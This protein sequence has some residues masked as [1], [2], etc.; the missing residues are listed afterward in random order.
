VTWSNVGS[1]A[2]QTASAYSVINRNTDYSS[3]NPMAG[4]PYQFSKPMN[5]T[6]AKPAG[7]V[8]QTVEPAG[9]RVQPSAYYL[10]RE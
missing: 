9:Y 1:T 3:A 10:P 7:T 5:N 4:L 2:S 8:N 6:S